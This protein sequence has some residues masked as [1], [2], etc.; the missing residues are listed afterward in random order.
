MRLGARLSCCTCTCTSPPLEHSWCTRRGLTLLATLD[1]RSGAPG[2]NKIEAVPSSL[3]RREPR[4]R[5]CSR[6]CPLPDA[7]SAAQFSRAPDSS[8]TK[9]N[10]NSRK[11]SLSSNARP[12][13]EKRETYGDRVATPGNLETLG[14]SSERVVGSRVT[15]LSSIFAR[16][17]LD[18]RSRRSTGRDDRKPRNF[19]KIVGARCRFKGDASLLD[20]YSIF[21]RF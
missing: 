6:L 19:R 15:L 7:A 4:A 9:R 20:F 18:F 3:L 10:N 16:F 13:P 21:A 2:R 12:V 11:S 17:S 5:D 8:A 1:A 14:K